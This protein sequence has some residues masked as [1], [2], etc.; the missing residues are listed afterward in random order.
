MPIYGSMI[1]FGLLRT[2][3]SCWIS[4]RLGGGKTLLAFR[5]AYDL[6]DSGFV[7]HLVSNIPSVWS[8]NPWDIE[9]DSN[10][11]LNTVV[12]LDEGGLYLRT[13]KD[14]DEYM[15]F[16][17]KMNVVIIV[18]S[19]RKPA[20]ALRDFVIERVFNFQM[21]GLPW[22][23]Y[24]YYLTTAGAK[25]E[26]KFLYTNP[27]EMYG[28]FDSKAMPVDDMGISEWLNGHKER[29]VNEYYKQHGR[30]HKPGKSRSARIVSGM[31]A[32]GGLSGELQEAAEEFSHAASVISVSNKGKGRGR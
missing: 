3:R 10:N 18:P 19:V 1:P 27:S 8:E 6:L 20:P 32:N 2:F 26:A 23:L 9:L 12:V 29:L 16:A 31:G 13:G 7:K 28:I 4:G 15:T 30:G 24:K 11:M 25:D 22:W 5:M 17:R 21:L 14:V